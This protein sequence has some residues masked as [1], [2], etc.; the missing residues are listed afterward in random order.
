MHLSNQLAI[1]LGNH[2]K[3]VYGNYIL[4]PDYVTCSDLQ[5]SSSQKFA[6]KILNYMQDGK[7]HVPVVPT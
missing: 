5:A 6:P 7:L 3:M 1:Y 4:P 2:P